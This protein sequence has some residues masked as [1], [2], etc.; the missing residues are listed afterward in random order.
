M[1]IA[2]IAVMAMVATPSTVGAVAGFGDVSSSTYYAA[3]VQWMVDREITTG[4][5]ACSYSP[6]DAVTRG[7]AAAF[8][9]RMEGRPNPRGG[10]PFNDVYVGWQQTPVSWM[11]QNGITEGVTPR[12]YQ[13]DALVTRGQ[14][15]AMLYRLAGEPPVAVAFAFVDVREGWQ[16]APVAWM[17]N[18]GITKGVTPTT[19]RPDDPVSR[20]QAAAFLHRYKGSPRVTVTTDGDCHVLPGDGE[21]P[22]P[23]PVLGRG[24]ISNSANFAADYRDFGSPW[25]IHDVDIVSNGG[26]GVGPPQ[27]GPGLMVNSSVRINNGADNIKLSSGGVYRN[28][29]LRMGA[30][31]GHLDAIQGQGETNWVIDNVVIEIPSPHDGVTGAIFIQNMMGGGQGYS[32]VTG[33]INRLKLIGTGPF[34]HDIRFGSSG[35]KRTTITLTNVD[36]SEA[37]PD[38][39]LVLTGSPSTLTVYL[40]DSV[41]A[42]RITGAEN[43]TIIRI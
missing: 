33:V 43:A 12:S 36:W 2:V 25:Y 21:W 4:T 22:V 37:H 14:F 40:D 17:S 8:L 19:F 41:P 7:Q 16:L 27:S 11:Y 31:G 23:G 35:G 6:L 42:S 20:A 18:L 10:H 38:S 9:W 32:D 5:T 29:Y 39:H 28:L 30:S 1:V 13:P 34:H 26:N 24:Q 15:A 3:P